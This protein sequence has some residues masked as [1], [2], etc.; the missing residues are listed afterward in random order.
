[1]ELVDVIKGLKESKVNFVIVGGYAKYL[2]GLTELINDIDIFIPKYNNSLIN[3]RS[4]F[5]NWN[6]IEKGNDLYSGKIIRIFAKDYT[7][8]LLPKL[9][10]LNEM[11]VFEESEI[12]FAFG[13]Y[14][15]VI[16][17]KHLK[18]NLLA[19]EKYMI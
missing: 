6:F 9:D 4:F 17:M 12:F 11:D 1:M 18:I 5:G 10:G 7:I 2:H 14:I 15:R 3:I 8:D 16:N 13:E 19:L